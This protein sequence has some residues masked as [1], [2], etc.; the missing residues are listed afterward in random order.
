M[1]RKCHR[2]VCTCRDDDDV[3]LVEGNPRGVLGVLLVPAQGCDLERSPHQRAGAGVLSETNNAFIYLTGVLEKKLQGIR[4]FG[5]ATD[6]P[7][8]DIW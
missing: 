1:Y 7:V 4:S 8:L 6:T 5:R 3:M 2:K